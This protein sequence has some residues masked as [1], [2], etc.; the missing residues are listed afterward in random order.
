MKPSERG[1][2]LI[3]LLIVVA[4]ILVVAAIAIPMLF[5][6]KMAANE[7]VTVA[8]LKAINAGLSIYNITYPTCGFPDSLTRLAAGTPPN[9]ANAGLLDPTMANDN[10]DKSGYRF[11]YVLTQGVGDCTGTLGAAYEVEARPVILDKTGRR[12]FYTDV[13]QVIR[14]DRDGDA[15]PTS[16][17]I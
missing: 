1:F 5:Q 3:E 17:P 2:S 7:S 9:S 14:A 8:N 12:G 11:S 13:T 15:E 10:F 4:I 6:S 16:P